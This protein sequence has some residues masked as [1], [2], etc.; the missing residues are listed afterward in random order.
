[1]EQII[2]LGCGGHACSVVDSII[3][4]GYYEI[5]GFIERENGKGIGF[6]E[7][8]VIGTDHDLQAIY[9]AGVRNA[10]VTI[11]YLGKSN[12]R[13]KVYSNLKQIGYHIPKIIDPSAILARGVQME[14]GTYIGKRAV[15]NTNS[16]IGKMCIINTGAIVEHGNVIEDFSHVSV[17]SVL[18]GD[19]KLGKGTLIG[20]NA[21]VIQGI[22]IG[23]NVIVG[24]GVTVRHHI[25]SGRVYYEK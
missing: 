16:Y 21:A 18:C 24:A 19:V 5:I 9:N 6:A 2:L 13:E 4:L 22:H 3:Q 10:F 17:G 12:I 1:M 8:S 20:A 25:E 14:E 23:D 11:G 15:V 7:Y